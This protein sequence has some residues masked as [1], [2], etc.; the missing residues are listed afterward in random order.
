ME[1]THSIYA[2]YWTILLSRVGWVWVVAH[3]LDPALRLVA[4]VHFIHFMLAAPT[5]VTQVGLWV[6]CY[7]ALELQHTAVAQQQL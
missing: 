5:H 7:L 2:E 4:F 3:R 6:F 1:E